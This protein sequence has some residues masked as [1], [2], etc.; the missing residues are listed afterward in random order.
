MIT[1]DNVFADNEPYMDGFEGKGNAGAN[2]FSESGNIDLSFG[3]IEVSQLEIKYFFTNDAISNPGSQK[4]GISDLNF[5]V[6]SV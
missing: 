3:S 1:D 4:I 5:Q 6:Q 2:N